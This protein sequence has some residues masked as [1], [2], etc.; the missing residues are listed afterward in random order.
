MSLQNACSVSCSWSMQWMKHPR[1]PCPTVST[2]VCSNSCPLSWWCY[3]TI[4]LCR[5]L[6]LCLQFFQH[7]GLFQWVIFSH[8]VV[9]VLELQ[10]QHQSFQWIFRVDFLLVRLVWSCS[11]RDS[12]ESSSVSQLSI[13]FSALSLLYGPTLT[14]IHDYWK[15]H[16]SKVM[17]LLF[18]NTL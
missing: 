18:N 16:N 6:L 13:N 15:N 4:I 10:L 9:R 3:L 17:S 12:E 5:P 2:T 1:L 7:Q 14:S 11:A 8:K